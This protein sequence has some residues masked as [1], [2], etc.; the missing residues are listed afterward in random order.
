MNAVEAVEQLGALGRKLQAREVGLQQP[1]LRLQ[2]VLRQSVDW[3]KVLGDPV[4]AL[5]QL[6]GTAGGGQ[7]RAKDSESAPEAPVSALPLARVSVGRGSPAGGKWNL[8]RAQRVWQWAERRYG[9]WL[10]VKL[11]A[12]G[13]DETGAAADIA[14]GDLERQL[15]GPRAWEDGRTGQ[16]RCAYRRSESGEASGCAGRGCR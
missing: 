6:L 16:R 3:E 13:W 14:A 7:A 15:G 8:D 11:W 4:A 5:S 9:I 1:S 12:G 10:W 2:A